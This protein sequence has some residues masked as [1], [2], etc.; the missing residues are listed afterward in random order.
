M[1]EV[2]VKLYTIK[3]LSEEARN[4]VIEKERRHQHE[5]GDR[6]YL[7]QESFEE[8]LED[9]GLPTENIMWSLSSCQGD[10]TAFTG[11]IDLEAY[12]KKNDLKELFGA[13]YDRSTYHIKHS[14]SYTH[15]NSMFVSHSVDEMDDVSLWYGCENCDDRFRCLANGKCE[16]CEG[17]I[18]LADELRDHI[19]AH[20]VT[21]SKE[22]E[23]LGYEIIE[24]EHKDE[25]II[26]NLEAN[27]VMFFESGK[28]FCV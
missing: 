14:G 1:Q 3:E 21:V 9:Y 4:K 26:D 24:Y 2:I 11:W 15:Y 13:L 17:L 12:F 7:L 20:I 28:V 10:G 22:L 8:K 6:R 16:V 27:D 18:D 5:F 19:E 23:K 25:T